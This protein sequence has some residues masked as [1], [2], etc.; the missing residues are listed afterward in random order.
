MVNEYLN[1]STQ[2]KNLEYSYE[3]QLI[4]EAIERDQ[5]SWNF[6]LSYAKGD[7][8][9]ENNPLFSPFPVGQESGTSS[10][11]ISKDNIYG[12]SFTFSGVQQKVDYTSNGSMYKLYTQEIGYSQDLGANF[13]GRTD[14]LSLEVEELKSATQKT[15]LQAN[16]SKSLME[17]INDYLNV[18]R[19]MTIESLQNEA[20][21]RSQSRLKLVSNQVKDG[22]KERVDLL[23]TRN[24]H[25]FQIEQV[26]S[27]K[28]NTNSS[29]LNLGTKLERE[30]KKGEVKLYK[31]SKAYMKPISEKSIDNNLSIQAVNKKIT[32]LNT[33]VKKNKKSIF[34]S[35]ALNVTY[36]T[37]NYEIDDSSPISDGTVGSDN[38]NI[39]YGVTVTIPLGFDTQKNA[40]KAARLAK[41]HAEYEQKITRTTVKN[42]VSEILRSI[43]SLDKN[44]NS[45]VNRYRLANDT[46]KEYNRLYSR[47]R[48]SLDQV[49][50]AE[51]DLITTEKAFVQ[52]QVE[53]EKRYYALLD[54]Y[55]ELEEQFSK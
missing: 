19:D 35:I 49:I 54:L 55:G 36:G 50:R 7:D 12:G 29:L 13:L 31:I 17:F 5:R 34:P 39:E 53:R 6:V 44:I 1:S 42:R 47:G 2:V 46:L 48:V 4:S 26:N 3:N 37:N 14:K 28:T 45:V 43:K 25:F 21:K 41:M 9:Q 32:Y 18:K 11:A 51:E 22:L 40:L 23:S 16:R 30:I 10:L 24:S 38:K 52:Y 8:E 27:A 20:L 15:E 33:E